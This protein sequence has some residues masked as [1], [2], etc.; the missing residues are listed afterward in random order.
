MTKKKKVE[1]EEE[2]S[3]IYY[4]EYVEELLEDDEITPE[5]EA[6]MLGYNEAA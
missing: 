1:F 5:E 3:D 6:F 4:N 2:L